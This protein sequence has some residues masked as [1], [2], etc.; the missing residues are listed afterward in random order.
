MTS[1][2]AAR[3]RRLPK[4]RRARG[5][6]LYAQD[7][8]RFLDLWQAGGR[9]FLGHRGGG[10]VTT[11]KRVLDRGVLAPLPSA[12]EHRLEQALERLLGREI[13]PQTTGG[14]AARYRVLVFSG[15]ERAFDVLSR[16]LGLPYGGDADDGY[17]LVGGSAAEP[18]MMRGDEGGPATGRADACVW[19]PL[20]PPAAQPPWGDD[21]S[22]I[23]PVLPDGGFSRAQV[24]LVPR[25]L[26]AR[27]GGEYR[28]GL[29]SDL[30]PEP[31][32][33]A[34]TAGAH[35]LV[36]PVVR[37]VVALNGFRSVGPYLMPHRMTPDEYDAVF[38]R[39]LTA[40]IVISPDPAIPSIVPGELSDGELAQLVATGRG[41]RGDGGN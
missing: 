2:A 17:A 40:G 18:A 39:F 23:V 7:G 15:P 21:R 27:D 22:V 38:E 1:E 34:L 11:L 4:I 9:A 20:L 41:E 25:G 32:L 37:P 30:L 6:R 19:R 3:L 5:Y 24:V 12:Q 33:A 14:L 10:I 36:S 16:T 8:R 31:V 26:V 35:G 13:D 29:S 28:V